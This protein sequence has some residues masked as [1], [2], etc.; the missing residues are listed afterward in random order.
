MQEKNFHK[1]PHCHNIMKSLKTVS[2]KLRISNAIDPIKIVG[3]VIIN[4]FL[5]KIEFLLFSREN[6]KFNI[7]FVH[8]FETH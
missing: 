2:G 8:E 3:N 7:F 5:W 4:P 1:I 6:R